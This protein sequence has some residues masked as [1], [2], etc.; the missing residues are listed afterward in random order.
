MKLIIGGRAQGKLDYAKLNI[1]KEYVVYD[2]V[3]PDDN[4]DGNPVC[5]KIIIVNHF[6]EFVR[7]EM[8]E[9]G[10]PKEEIF[11]FLDKHDDV[12]IISDEVG[13]GIVPVDAFER[14]YRETTGRILGELAKR[15]DTVVRVI[16]G[17]G[18]V[19]K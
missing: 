8:K 3:M 11:S 1:D 16:C 17:I 18:Q 15:A 9:N 7:K 10:N 13:N 6:H 12:I 14:E 19:I 2:G 5:D 4:S